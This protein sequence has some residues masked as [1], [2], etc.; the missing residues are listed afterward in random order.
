MAAAIACMGAA[1][2]SA[3]ETV[4]SPAMSPAECQVADWKAVGYQD[5]ANG[6]GAERFVP[7][8]Q[9]CVAA[10]YGADQDAYMA[11]RR[12]GLW[13]WCQPER[14]FRM[15]LGGSSYNGVC[16]IELDG[17]FRDAHAEGFRAWR[18][19]SDLRDAEGKVTSLRSE[20]DAIESKI[21]ANEAGLIASQTDSERERHRNELIRLRDERN[22]LMSRRRDA[23]R[24]AYDAGR[25]VQR[26]RGEIGFR[27]GS[28]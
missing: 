1:M 10:G 22:R 7:R 28:W 27:Y 20:I 18:A 9:A 26:L 21:D 13:T 15:G 16:P 12:E 2:L 19:M 5:G 24:D 4:G 3:C 23:E 11:G 6:R 25:F 8:Q 14:A 17:V